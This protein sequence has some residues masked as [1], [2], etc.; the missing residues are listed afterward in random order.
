M[1]IEISRENNKNDT[2]R[3]SQI[4]MDKFLNIFTKYSNIPN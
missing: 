4:T 1:Y 3:Y 2:E